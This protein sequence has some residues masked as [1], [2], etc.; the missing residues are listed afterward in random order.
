MVLKRLLLSAG[1]FASFSTALLAD[2]YNPVQ[3]GADNPVQ[4]GEDEKGFYGVVSIGFDDIKPIDWDSTISGTEYGGEGYI[5]SGTVKEFGFGYDFGKFRAEAAYSE[6]DVHFNGCTEVRVSGTGCTNNGNAD[7]IKSVI[8]SGFYDIPTKSKLT[9]Y[10]GAGI[11]MT[12]IDPG[13]NKQVIG[14]T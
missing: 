2:S 4:A 8:F 12:D 6:S 11:G 14:G 7:E 9:P 1:I 5:D 10:I 3:A 13:N